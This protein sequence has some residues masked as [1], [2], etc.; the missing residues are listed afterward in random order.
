MNTLIERFS[1]PFSATDWNKDLRL[2]KN[3]NFERVLAIGDTHCGSIHGLTPP[4]TISVSGDNLAARTEDE[5]R[6]CWN[7]FAEKVDALRPIDVLMFNGDAI[8][9]KAAAQEGLEQLTVDMLEQV[10]MATKIV[11]FINPERAVF[12]YGTPYHTGKGEDFE[13]ILADNVGAPISSVEQ[14]SVG[15][16]VFDMRHH[17]GRSGVPHGR[18][19]PLAREQ[20]WNLLWATR[21]DF[22]LADV[23]LRSHVHYF[24]YTGGP[25]WVAMSLPALQMPG[26][27]FGVRR[28]TGI[29]DFGLAYFDVKDGGYTWGYELLEGRDAPW[30]HE[31]RGI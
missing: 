6:E 22:P 4:N 18:Q 11:E 31:A 8:D 3:R 10:E 30:A 20:L 24:T 19:T 13:K 16:V 29:V 1:G 21:G 23:I 15:G 27:R 25:D 7:W 12:T 14:V 17:L 5:R 26:T 2:E 28:M 9:G